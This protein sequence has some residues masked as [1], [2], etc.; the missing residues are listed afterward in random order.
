MSSSLCNVLSFCLLALLVA[1][2]SYKLIVS[3]YEYF[4]NQENIY[5]LTNHDNNHD[6]LKLIYQKVTG[7]IVNNNMLFT[8]YLNYY[9]TEVNKREF[10]VRSKFYGRNELYLLY[11]MYFIFFKNNILFFNFGFKS[12]ED[13]NVCIF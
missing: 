11:I 8:H 2:S 5:V 12:H 10:I 7:V 4:V 6:T 13:V 9:F 3:C 1:I